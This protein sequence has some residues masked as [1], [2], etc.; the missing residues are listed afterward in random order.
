MHRLL[1]KSM[2]IVNRYVSL[3]FLQKY[4]G[5]F[6]VDLEGN[7]S[8][9]FYDPAMSMISSA[10]RVDDHLYIGSLQYRHIIRFNL[11]RL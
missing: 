9:H 10:I 1:R 3:E 6:S 5:I 4:G 2:V 7:P 8:A 11:S